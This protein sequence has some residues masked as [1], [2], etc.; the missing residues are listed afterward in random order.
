[1]DYKKAFDLI[2]HHILVT[3]LHSLDIP[4]EIINWVSVF[5]T[6][7]QQRVK[8]ASD[9]YSEWAAVPA[10]VPQGTKLGLWLYILMINDLNA[11]GV[12][13][14]KFVDDTTITEE[15][16]KGDT[17][18]MQLATNKIQDQSINLKF[19]LNKNK[20]KE[21]RVCFAKL[22]RPDILP[23]VINNKEIE[24]TFSAKILG[25]IVGSDLKWNDQSNFEEIIQTIVLSTA[26]E[27]CKSFR[28]G[29]DSV[30]LYLCPPCFGICLPRIS[31]QFAILSE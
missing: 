23:V 9:C 15:V 1:M 4:P 27:T 18:K 29:N 13:L 10:G 11:N 5:L 17:S 24:L 16:P 25:L 14:W 26:I 28:K 8:L 21:M 2:D 3:K 20:C 22:E 12:D 31:L 7:R 19:T 30:L 6:N